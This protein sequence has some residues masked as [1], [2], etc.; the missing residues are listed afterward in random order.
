[1]VAVS[2]CGL[3]DC[4]RACLGQWVFL[5]VSAVLSVCLGASVS[6]SLSPFKV[7]LDFTEGPSSISLAFVPVSVVFFSF[8]WFF[9]RWSSGLTGITG[10]P[11][12][13]SLCWQVNP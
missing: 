4:V 11:M 2:A 3:F 1:M 12:P 5:A 8:W 13:S 7:L 6:R 10:L 9:L